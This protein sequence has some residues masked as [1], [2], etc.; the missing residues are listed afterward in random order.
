MTIPTPQESAGRRIDRL[1][2]EAGCTAKELDA[3]AAYV[4]LDSL[5][6]AA[7]EV[8]VPLSTLRSRLDAAE[9][10]ILRYID[11]QKGTAA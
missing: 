4:R 2:R 8:G 10:R 1:A 6:L 7:L 9:A 3:L 5:R 11:Q